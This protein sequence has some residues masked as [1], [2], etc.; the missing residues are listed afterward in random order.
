M[1]FGGSWTK[2]SNNGN[3]ELSINGKVFLDKWKIYSPEEF[4]S[5]RVGD[6]QQRESRN[7]YTFGFGYAQVISKR[8]QA[9]VS[10]EVVYQNGVL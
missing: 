6:G 4:R 8:L 2:E 5:R 9:S 3:R 10:S 7:S 1:S